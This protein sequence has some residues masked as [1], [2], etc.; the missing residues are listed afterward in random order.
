M[1]DIHVA[2]DPQ[3]RPEDRPAG[4][5]PPLVRQDAIGGFTGRRCGPTKTESA[6]SD[7]GN[8]DPFFDPICPRLI[9]RQARVRNLE[10]SAAVTQR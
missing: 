3:C 2:R 6:R 8:R 4:A 5:T 1:G 9:L 10:S 7:R